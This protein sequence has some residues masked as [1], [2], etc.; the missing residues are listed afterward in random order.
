MFSCVHVSVAPAFTARAPG[1]SRTWLASNLQPASHLRAL[2]ATCSAYNLC[3]STLLH[4]PQ[5]AAR[6]PP[7]S[8][9]ISPRT[10]EDGRTGQK[11]WGQGEGARG[12]RGGSIGQGEDSRGRRGGAKV[13]AGAAGRSRLLLVG[14]PLVFDTLARIPLPLSQTKPS[15]ACYAPWQDL[16][17]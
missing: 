13:K 8:I 3:Y 9:T 7:D 17:L 1:T 14:P 2:L 6:L 4:D 10:V 11:G 15:L 16:P 12:R 5:D